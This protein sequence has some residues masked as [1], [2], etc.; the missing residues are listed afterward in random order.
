MPVL[1]SFSV[2]ELRSVQI[3]DY[4]WKISLAEYPTKAS[5]DDIDDNDMIKVLANS[6]VQYSACSSFAALSGNTDLQL[7][8]T[9]QRTDDQSEDE[10]NSEDEEWEEEPLKYLRTVKIDPFVCHVLVSLSGLFLSRLLGK[11]VSTNYNIP[12]SHQQNVFS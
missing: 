9:S 6:S 12:N 1:F 4:S 7:Q 8:N 10:F 5:T 11:N 2:F 3:A